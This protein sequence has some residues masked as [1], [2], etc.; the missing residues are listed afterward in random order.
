MARATE[1][2]DIERVGVVRMSGFNVIG[3]IAM[4][5]GGAANDGTFTDSGPESV[6]GG[7]HDMAAIIVTNAPGLVD[8]SFTFSIGV[9]PFGRTLGSARLAVGLVGIESGDVFGRLAAWAGFDGKEV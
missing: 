5:A 9:M 6:S 3:R 8:L 4:G 1:P 2:G 7:K